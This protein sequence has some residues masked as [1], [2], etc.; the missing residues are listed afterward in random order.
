MLLDY[1]YRQSTKEFFKKRFLRVVVP[2]LIWSVF[3]YWYSYHYYAFPG[4][5][6]RNVFS[7]VTLFNHLWMIR[8]IV[9]SGSSFRSF[10]STWPPQSLRC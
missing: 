2:F 7:Y 5:F 9:C 3:Y 8:S 1:R 4:I 10:S 6:H